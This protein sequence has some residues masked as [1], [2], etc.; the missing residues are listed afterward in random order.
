[1]S[2][3]IRPGSREFTAMKKI[4]NQYSAKEKQDLSCAW[5][6]QLLLN[7]AIKYGRRGQL[8]AVYVTLVQPSLTVRENFR[9]QIDLATSKKTCLGLHGTSFAAVNAIF[10]KGFDAGRRKVV[11]GYDSQA[12]F[13]IKLRVWVGPLSVAVLC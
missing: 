7:K 2:S 9:R 3:V 4:S 5:I 12:T 10:E 8:Q 1:M 6:Y 13:W 11:F